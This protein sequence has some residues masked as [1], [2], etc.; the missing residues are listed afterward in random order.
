MS[1]E[2]KT[3]LWQLQGFYL[4]I[5]SS[6]KLSK[7]NELFGREDIFVRR[8]FATSI[9]EKNQKWLVTTEQHTSVDQACENW[10][11]SVIYSI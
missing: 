1:I 11:K 2:E 6:F 3:E 9:P 10:F 7:L 8:N 4:T 5:H